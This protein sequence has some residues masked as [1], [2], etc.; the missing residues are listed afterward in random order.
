[1]GLKAFHSRREIGRSVVVG[2]AAAGLVGTALAGAVMAPAGAVAVAAGV[3]PRVATDDTVL[4]T[5]E[6]LGA[7]VNDLV[8]ALAVSG[9][10]TVYA[11]GS[12]TA[13][14][15][16]PDTTKIAAWSNA[17]DTWH[18]LGTGITTHQVY[19]PVSALALQGDDTVYA[20]GYFRDDTSASGVPG[21]RNIAAWSN[22]D[23][24]W[25]ALGTG[26]SDGGNQVS[27]LALQGDDTVY[28]GGAFAFASGVPGTR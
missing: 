11:G 15:G 7:G 5:F 18:A 4:G 17:D 27:A 14:I 28:A 2:V 1:M 3:S 13:A 24:T 16:V 8:R 9:D 21:T 10:D 19:R 12:F 23:D 6:A 26:M 20:G 25:H 22:A